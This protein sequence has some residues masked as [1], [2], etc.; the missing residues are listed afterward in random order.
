MNR[1]AVR[2][3][4]GYHRP[5][6]RIRIDHVITRLILGGAQENTV[7]TCEGLHALPGYDVRLIT[8]PPLGP[9]GD[10][11]RRARAGGYPVVVV[12]AMRRSIHPWRDLVSFVALV[13]LFRERR[14]HIV[15]TH[16]SKAGILGRA[17]ARLAG[18]PVVIHTIHGLPFH[19]YQSAAESAVYRLLEQLCGAMADALVCVGEVMRRK[20]IAARLAPPSRFH[21]VYSGM[22]VD[23]FRDGPP[24]ARARLGFS[25]E[26]VVVGVISRLAPLKGHEHLIDAARELRARWPTLRLLFVGDG[27]LRAELERRGAGLVTFTGLVEPDAIPELLRAMDV[28]AHT[29][30]REGLPRAVPQALLCERPVVAFDCDGAREVVIDGQTGYLVPAAST[31]GLRDALARVLERPDRG[32]G[33]GRRGRERFAAQFDARRMVA[34]LDRLYR[35]LV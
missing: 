3:Q 9:E 12:D 27:A 14:P 33:M 26:D 24:E 23:R 2:G 31:A 7:L 35:G 30:L 28:V 10:L 6:A 29:S 25:A 34:D 16:S 20:A 22:E 21:V 5:V 32:R 1:E 18:V 13:R 8:G 19:E 4:R 15:H 17:A 11:L